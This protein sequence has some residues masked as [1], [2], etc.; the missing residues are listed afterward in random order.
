MGHFLAVSAFRPVTPENLASAIVGVASSFDVAASVVSGGPVEEDQAAVHAT[1]GGWT[2]VIWPEGFNLHD[3]A[4]AA[5]V[6]GLIGGVASTVHI[7]DDDYWTHAVVQDGSVL[8]VFC[9]MPTYFDDDPALIE[10][11]AGRPQVVA[12]AV[13][14]D[15]ELVARYLRLAKDAESEKAFDDDRFTIDDPWVFTDLWTRLGI[16]YPDDSQDAVAIVQLGEGWTVALPENPS[17]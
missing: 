8:D 1:V 5:A 3:I 6:T 17:I 9:S 10:R 13:A 7:Y 15:P 12:D 2:V 16:T 11:Y 14:A 4:V